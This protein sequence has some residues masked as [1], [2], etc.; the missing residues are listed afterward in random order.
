M[1]LCGVLFVMIMSRIC[2]EDSGGL[3]EN[4]S[5][6]L[7]MVLL[8]FMCILYLSVCDVVLMVI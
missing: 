4:F 5:D 7:E 8:S 3:E 1:L 6:G 2:L